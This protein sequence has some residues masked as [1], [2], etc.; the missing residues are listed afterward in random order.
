MRP[1]YDLSKLK[2]EKDLDLTH[3]KE[4]GM[5]SGSPRKDRWLVYL[6]GCL[7]FIG[8]LYFGL[9]RFLGLSGGV[10]LLI[11]IPVGTVGFF[12][13]ARIAEDWESGGWDWDA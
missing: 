8:I 2:G 6:L 9:T 10:S 13:F 5:Y 1:R 12:V 3:F 7:V 11:S 4:P